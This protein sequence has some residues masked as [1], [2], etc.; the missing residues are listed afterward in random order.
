MNDRPKALGPGEL[1][2]RLREGLLTLG[3]DPRENIQRLT[4][5]CGELLGAD[6]A[7][8]NRIE[9]GTLCVTGRWQAPADLAPR[10]PAEGH[11]CLDVVGN[12][13]QTPLLIRDL[14]RTTYADTDA[15]VLRYGLRTYLGF[16]V[17]RGRAAVGSL[18]ALFLRDFDPTDAHGQV[19]GLLAAAVGIE[20]ARL[21]AAT[22]E[23]GQISGSQCF[24]H[25]LPVGVF[26]VDA[27]THRIVDVNPAALD[28]IGARREAVVGKLC[29]HFLGSAEPRRASPA[30]SDPSPGPCRRTLVK[31]DGTRR[32]VLGWVR[33]VRGDGRSLLLECVLATDEAPEL[34]LPSGA[35]RARAGTCVLA[36]GLR[37][38]TAG[39]VTESLRAAGCTATQAASAA[40]ALDS[41]TR[42]AQVSATLDSVLVDAGLT[43]IDASQFA[44]L[45]RE[46]QRLAATRLVLFQPGAASND[47]S[48]DVGGYAAR[49]GLPLD[50]DAVLGRGKAGSDLSFAT[51]RTSGERRAS[52]AQ[53]GT[54]GY[55]LLVED[56]LINMEVAREMLERTGYQCRCV[57]NGQEALEAFKTSR[58]D[59]VLM[60]CQMP[61][62]DGYEAARR[63][64]EWEEV[65][66]GR[67]RVPIV[68]VTAHAMKGDRERCLA[69]GMDDYV[70]KPVEAR[71]LSAMLARWIHRGGP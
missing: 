59:L 68:A 3:A 7:L 20:E 71:R 2:T 57:S 62:V 51:A 40:E 48:A 15:T 67:L 39:P 10:S 38:E 17:R 64:R 21:A 12:N 9:E 43:G 35:E 54:S 25:S 53:A 52:R 14:P 45:V 5:L 47:G 69:A 58:F 33:E 60:D 8:Y 70:T 31:A 56:N 63:I 28:L 29:H 22:R 16:A 65:R 37:S 55:V 19:M 4:A 1:M 49:T 27:G 66:G 34:A 61:V 18:C 44:A 41:L 6:S 24:L 46:D 36:V 23:C 13:R 32:E 11:I 42:A 30:G 50:M 26:T